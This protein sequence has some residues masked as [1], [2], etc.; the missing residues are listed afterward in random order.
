[1]RFVF[2]GF[3]MFCSSRNL[4]RHALALALAGGFVPGAQAY[5]HP[6]V[7]PHH[8]VHHHVYVHTVVRQPGDI[9]VT[10]RT[11]SYLD[12][13]PTAD[14]GSENLYFSD[15]AYPHYL[16]GPGILQRFDEATGMTY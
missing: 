1:L 5:H 12:P 15:T 8:P 13:G 9:Y 14:E 16:L 10:R 2:K 6:P 7:K 11:R 4:I 3:F